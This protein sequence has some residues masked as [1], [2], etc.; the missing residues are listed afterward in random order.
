P[1]EGV[2]LVHRK[3]REHRLAAPERVRLEELR[4]DLA[5]VRGRRPPS[6][7][8]LFLLLEEP[9]PGPDGPPL[10]RDQPA[11]IPLRPEVRDGPAAFVLGL[12]GDVVARMHHEPLALA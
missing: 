1:Q 4:E 9:S 7:L 6:V 2:V 10:L 11:S 5:R 12:L 8:L 3:G